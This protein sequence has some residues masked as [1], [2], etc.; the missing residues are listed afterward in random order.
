MGNINN[1][2]YNEV[3]EKYTII[4]V[5]KAVEIW[6]NINQANKPERRQRLWHTLNR[7]GQIRVTEQFYTLGE[8]AEEY[9]ENGRTYVENNSKVKTRNILLSSFNVFARDRFVS[10]KAIE[11]NMRNRYIYDK[12]DEEWRRFSDKEKNYYRNEANRRNIY[13]QRERK[14]EWKEAK[15]PLEPIPPIIGLKALTCEGCKPLQPLRELTIEEKLN[16]HLE[17]ENWDKLSEVF[18]DPTVDWSKVNIEPNMF[19]TPI[20]NIVGIRRIK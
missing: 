13:R 17:A 3:Y 19:L 11:P 15:M 4:E 18:N 10:I 16:I 9:L 2:I 7:D 6:H 20:P 14:E 1:K 12:I 5:S 8:E